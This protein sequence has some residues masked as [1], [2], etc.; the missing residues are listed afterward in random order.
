V[1]GSHFERRKD[2]G[3]RIEKSPKREG[4]WGI[5]VGKDEALSPGE[6]FPGREEKGFDRPKKK[7]VEG[8]RESGAWIN[9]REISRGEKRRRREI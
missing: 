7:Y 5:A 2:W 9:K 4:T 6:G 1:K 8:N 3:K